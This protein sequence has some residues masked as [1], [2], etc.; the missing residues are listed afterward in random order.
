MNEMLINRKKLEVTVLL[1]IIMFSQTISELIPASSLSVPRIGKFFFHYA[2][3]TI[4]LIFKCYKSSLFYVC[5]G[6]K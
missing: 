5:N 3:L 2:N 1:V 6:Y 4:K